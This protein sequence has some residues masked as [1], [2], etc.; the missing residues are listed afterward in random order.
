MMTQKKI[1]PNFREQAGSFFDP[2]KAAA[3]GDAPQP[4]VQV[5]GRSVHLPVKSLVWNQSALIAFRGGSTSFISIDS[6]HSEFITDTSR[7]GI[8]RYLLSCQPIQ[9]LGLD[10]SS[11]VPA[12]ARQSEYS[13]T[14]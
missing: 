7:A 4:Q 11:L 6:I 2:V 3:I 13:R 5:E 9:I 1:Q 10:T 8:D 12:S 14:K